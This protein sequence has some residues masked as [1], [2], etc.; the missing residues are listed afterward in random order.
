MWASGVA[1][2]WPERSRSNEF[3]QP[4]HNS[5]TNNNTTTTASANGIRNMVNVP[6]LEE[7]LDASVDAL[8][9]GWT[10]Q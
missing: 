4:S 9:Q 5:N 2:V 6:E 3:N 7:G 8:V 1:G 10:E